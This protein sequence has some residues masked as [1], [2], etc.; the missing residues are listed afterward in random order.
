[1]NTQLV[2]IKELLVKIASFLKKNDECQYSK[3]L[4]DVLLNGDNEILQFIVSN[5]LWGGAGSIA[6]QALI[7]N[8]EARKNLEALLIELGGIQKEAGQ[9]N[10][11]TESWIAAFKAWRKQ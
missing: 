11:R 3:M 5:E 1:M 8:S 10:V 9:L 7:E 4:E 6:D 2:E